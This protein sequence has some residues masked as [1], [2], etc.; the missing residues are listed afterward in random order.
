MSSQ[1]DLAAQYLNGSMIDLSPSFKHA[2]DIMESTKKNLFITGKAGTGKSTLLEYFRERTQKNIAV[3]APTGVAAL[4]VH[5]Q[6]IH[7]FF[8]FKPGITRDSVKRLSHRQRDQYLKLDTIIIDEISM[9]RADLLDCIDAFM[10][11]NGSNDKLPFGGA[12]IIFIGDL[13]Q[14]PPV[15]THSEAAMFKVNYESE[16]FFDADVFKEMEL[17]FVELDKHYRQTDDSFIKILNAIRNGSATESDIAQINSRYD[18]KF[19][20]KIN[21]RYITLTT[22]NKIAEEINDAELAKLTG[23][24]FYYHGTTEG[25]FDAKALPTKEDI[26]LRIGS[27]VML[28]NN[29]KMERWVNGSIGTVIS[30]TPQEGTNDIITVELENGERVEVLPFTWEMFK[31]AYDHEHRKLVQNKVGS[32]TQY[33]LMLA[34]A[35]TIHKSQGKTF[36]KVIIDLGYGTFAP[37]QLYVA[38]SRCTSM[39]GI[40]LKTRISARHMIMDNRVSG[41][42]SKVRNST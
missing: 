7:S 20:P 23:S 22:T 18:T 15:V 21:D 19:V 29:D 1:L 2:I 4:N 33:P 40:V 24:T 27:Q 16:Y 25:N 26:I 30:T 5:G 41:F 35:I 13:Y 32:F 36:K 3:L 12:Q 10:R 9:V 31:F 14:L 42:L 6:T 28:L 39:E 37:G 11:I 8:R 34:W 38:L 17:E